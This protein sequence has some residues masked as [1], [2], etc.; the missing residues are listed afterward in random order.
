MALLT[1]ISETNRIDEQGGTWNISIVPVWSYLVENV[2][3]FQWK[4]TVSFTKAY[5]Y[6]GLSESAAISIADDIREA[7]TIE[8]ERT[9][10]GWDK[11]DTPRWLYSYKKSKAT[12]ATATPTLMDGNIWQIAV[13]VSATM[14]RG[15]TQSTAP[16]PEAV[17]ALLDGIDDYPELPYTPPT[18]TNGGAQ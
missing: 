2:Y 13:N 9:I 3:Y 5:R 12:E 18:P 14:E 10:T 16:T 1:T 11:G 8:R 15:Y 4:A 6:V 17:R 7:Y